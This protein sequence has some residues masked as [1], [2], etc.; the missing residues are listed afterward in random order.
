MHLVRRFA[1]DART[2]KGNA[3]NAAYDALDAWLPYGVDRTR[4][5]VAVIDADGRL[6][7]DAL[8]YVSADSVFGDASVGAAQIAVRMENR[9][10]PRP[11]GPALAVRVSA[12]R[13]SWCACRTSSS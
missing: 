3:L 10:R 4:T 12:S 1:P 5:I 9:G 6:A 13:P 2:G 11:G 7:P 8:A